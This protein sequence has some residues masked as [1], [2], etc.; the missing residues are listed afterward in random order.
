VTKDFHVFVVPE[1][2]ILLGR[3]TLGKLSE[4]SLHRY[5]IIKKRI[6]FVTDNSYEY[7]NKKLEAT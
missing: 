7:V 2:R 5:N 6:P 3:K 1:H 4:A